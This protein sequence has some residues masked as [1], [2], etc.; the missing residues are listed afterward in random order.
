MNQSVISLNIKLKGGWTG[1]ERLDSVERYDPLLNSWKYCSAM[2]IAVS[3]PGV[4]NL[5]G[6]LYVIGGS[7][8]DGEVTNLVQ[9]YNPSHDEWKYLKSMEGAR[10]GCGSCA[11]NSKI[12]ALGGWES[13]NESLNLVESYDPK[14]D[15]WESCP[16]MISCR[17]KPGTNY[18]DLYLN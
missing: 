8:L 1:A 18:Y 15:T 16:T 3:S 12:Y 10:T 13:S 2:Q 5:N 9:V 11:F 4:C 17:H 7:V 6:L 14:T